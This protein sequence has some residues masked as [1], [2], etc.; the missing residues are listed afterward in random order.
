ML[1]VGSALSTLSCK[2]SPD[3]SSVSAD[4]AVS[5]PAAVQAA[6]SGVPTQTLPGLELRDSTPDLLL[7][8][9]ATDGEFHVT[10]SITDVPTERR[11]QVRVVPM[12]KP[13]GT[14]ATIYVA[15]L[16]A[17]TA[18]GT[19][20][21]A[22]MARSDWEALGAG[23]RS[24]RM[25]A[26]SPKALPKPSASPDKSPSA[27]LVSAIIYGADWCKPCHQAEDYL[28][29]LGVEVTKKNIEKSRAAQAEMREKLARI[30]R[31]SAGI[32][33]ID[34]MGS[35]FVGFSKASLKQAVEA[36]RQ[37]IAKAG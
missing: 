3:N 17:A 8:W 12:T 5:K 24:K 15:N 7:T 29:S 32:P 28:K 22:T 37:R 27:A 13:V 26:F 31:R 6:K 21:V 11:A 9:V 20:P 2:D 4:D 16:T 36:A 14:G 25:E 19:Y 34:V 33:V 18:D 30:Q 10:E 23:K 1:V 35:L